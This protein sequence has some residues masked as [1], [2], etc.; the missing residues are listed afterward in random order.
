MSNWLPWALLVFVALVL[1]AMPWR[2]P[3]PNHEFMLH[4]LRLLGD[5]GSDETQFIE[6]S[7]REDDV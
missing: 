6:N 2:R 5:E 4:M 3:H 1:A 7:P